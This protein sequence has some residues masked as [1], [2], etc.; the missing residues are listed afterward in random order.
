MPLFWTGQGLLVIAAAAVVLA[1]SQSPIARST[2]V[3]A[4][5]VGQWLNRVAYAPVRLEFSDELQHQRSAVEILQ[6][7]HL[8][9]VNYS[10]PVS[11]VYPGLESIAVGLVRLTGLPLHQA[12]LLTAGVGH[13]LGAAALLVLLRTLTPDSRAAALAALVYLVGPYAV[14]STMFAYQTLAIP[15]A[16]LVVGQTLRLGRTQRRARRLVLITLLSGLVVVTHH[17][18]GFATLAALACLSIA[19]ALYRASRSSAPWTAAATVVHAGLLGA[20]TL[21]VAHSVVGYLSRPLQELVSGV[22]TE[23]RGTGGA[24]GAGQPVI[25]RAFTYGA[26]LIP[27]VG[28]S[29]AIFIAWPRAQRFMATLS[30][31]AVA[32]QL[33]VIVIR[34]VASEGTELAG[35]AYAFTALLTA[36]ATAVVLTGAQDG[37]LSSSGRHHVRR[38]PSALHGARTAGCIALLIL[39]V[40]GVTAGWPPR[41]ERLPTYQVAGYE[42]AMD[43]HTIETAA[44]IEDSFEPGN[45]FAADFGNVTAVGTLGNQFP[46]RGSYAALFTDPN[47]A[48]AGDFVREYEI[49][50]LIVDNRLTRQLPPPDRGTWFNFDPLAGTYTRPIPAAALT[51]LDQVQG[52]QRLFDDGTIRVYDLRGSVYATGGP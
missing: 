15:I 45:R 26:I 25:E 17:L 13:V 16:I 10:L 12:A 41:Y 36:A 34:L 19:Q 52:V 37:R 18:T 3:I 22:A 23:E 4:Y 2:A 30:A 21:T 28:L 49:Q 46:I 5:S 24:P 40:G 50:Y 9:P 20:W 7:G 43:R 1:R 6:T 32:L 35:R 8:F 44:W 31:T 27:L 14:F 33:L 11:S 51:A 48:A 42:S 29:V 38:R 39:T 47:S